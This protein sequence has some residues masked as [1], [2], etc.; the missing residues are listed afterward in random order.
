MNEFRVSDRSAIV[1]GA[2]SGIGREVALLLA[3]SGCAVVVVDYD[4][5]GAKAVAEEVSQAGGAVLPV[6]GDVRDRDT[7][8]RA[9]VEAGRLAPLRVAVNN[10]GVGTGLDPIDKVTPEEWRRIMSIDLDAVNTCLQLQ[11]PAIAENGGGAVVN[12]ASALGLIARA[13]QSP[14][15][16]AKHGVIGLTKAAALDYAPQG[17]RVNA[18]CPGV[19][20]TPLVPQDDAIR[21]LLIAQHPIGRLG[22]PA[23]IAAMIAFLASDAASFVTGAAI[24][25][26]GGMTT[27]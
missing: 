12:T 8:E 11:L 18:V 15:I 7:V 10:A 23:E 20:D 27:G 14:Y 13:G 2:A 25:V 5:A 9:I 24:P 1:T 21:Q 22:H 3:G 16:T 17:V 6:V 19:V 4:E 26:D